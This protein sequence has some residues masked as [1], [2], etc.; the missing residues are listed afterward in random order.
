M[1]GKEG[2][3]RMKKSKRRKADNLNVKNQGEGE[4]RKKKKTGEERARET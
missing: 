1:R 4:K 2:A 3:H